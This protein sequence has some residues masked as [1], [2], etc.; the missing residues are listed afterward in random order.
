MFGIFGSKDV[1]DKIAQAMFDVAIIESIGPEE[2]AAAKS[3]GIDAEIYQI[4][5]FCLQMYI[6][7]VTFMMWKQG[8]LDPSKDKIVADKYYALIK[9]FTQRVSP[10][11]D[12]FYA[13]IV[14]RIHTYHE[15]QMR[16]LQAPDGVISME[17][18]R[19][20]METITSDPENVPY[21]FMQV[22]TSRFEFVGER[23]RKLLAPYTK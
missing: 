15:A 11:P 13:L 4:E 21:E 19:A 5:I 18:S 12:A 3:A 7:L 2:S 1:T 23:V 14:K 10:K 22:V 8:N 20:F 9:K 17:F 6:A 16:D